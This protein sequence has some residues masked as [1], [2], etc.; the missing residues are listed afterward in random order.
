MNTS[1]GD[2]HHDD[3]IVIE[4]FLR[5]FAISVIYLIDMCTR[6]KRIEI[7]QF[8]NQQVFYWAEAEKL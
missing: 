1:W 6:H 5:L 8:F 2:D 7:Q 4:F 3:N